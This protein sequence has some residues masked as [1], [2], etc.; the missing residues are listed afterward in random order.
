MLGNSIRD[1]S[2]TY[3]KV[4]CGLLTGWPTWLQAAGLEEEG[5]NGRGVRLHGAVKM[6]FSAL[7]HID[8]IHAKNGW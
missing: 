3:T 7:H 6:R 2:E 1:Q 5:H 4:L 8:I